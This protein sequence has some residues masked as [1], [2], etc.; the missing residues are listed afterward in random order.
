MEVHYPAYHYI[1]DI[2]S[3]TERSMSTIGQPPVIDLSE[4]IATTILSD[5]SKDTSFSD[6][7]ADLTDVFDPSKESTDFDDSGVSQ[8]H[9]VLC[10]ENVRVRHR[11]ALSSCEVLELDEEIEP[12]KVTN[13]TQP[14]KTSTPATVHSQTMLSATPYKNNSFVGDSRFNDSLNNL[15][16]SPDSSLHN[17]PFFNDLQAALANE[18]NSTAPTKD[19]LPQS[20]FDALT[21]QPNSDVFSR[22]QMLQERFNKLISTFPDDVRKLSEFYHH[23]ASEVE[24]ERFCALQQKDL[25][26]DV[27]YTMNCHYDSQLHQIMDRVEQSL[28]LLEKTQQMN[29]SSRA[30]KP[31]P[32]L[33][34]KA[35]QLMEKWYDNHL[36]HPYPNTDAIEQ[37]SAA[38]GITAE[39]VK[40]WF[41]NKRN[42]SNN[43]RTLTEIA[44]KK[45]QLA[46]KSMDY[47]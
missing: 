9:V 38:G 12:P 20:L 18:C 33:S 45:R 36:E 29:Y 23:Q 19:F 39:Q 6:D 27:K 16:G 4:V 1:D 28:N 17:N 14:L 30:I 32:L 44:K 21:T 7:L 40:K 37:L 47:F 26:S 46:L 8:D 2:E 10:G 42:R 5:N 22:E 43:T 41:A 24:T 13:K 11:S 31:R 25:A 3:A 35:V 15:L 34:K